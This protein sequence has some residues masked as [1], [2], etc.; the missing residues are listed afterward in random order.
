MDA[1]TLRETF[2]RDGIVF[3]DGVLRGSALASFQDQVSRE[4]SRPAIPPES[5]TP[6][7]V[8][9]SDPSTWP[10]GNAR[11]VIEVVP[12]G[13]GEHW[14]AL[15]TAPE[16]VRALD[17][18][19]GDGA[20]E[21][22][23]NQPHGGPC[24]VRHW[25]CPVVFPEAAA[26]DEPAA[27]DDP[28]RARARASWRRG[29]VGRDQRAW[30]PEEDAL[31]ARLRE[32]GREDEDDPAAAS[33]AALAAASPGEGEA[34]SPVP[35]EDSAAPLSWEA[36]AA[37]I[38]GGRTAK[39]CRE[40]YDPPWTP[41]QDAALLALVDRLGASWNR[42]ADRLQPARKCTK[43]QAR[44]R[45]DVLL[46]ARGGKDTA[47]RR[48]PTTGGEV[49]A[50][51]PDRILPNATVSRADPSSRWEPVNRRRVRG[52][53]WHVDVGPG[54]A[55]DGVRTS[56]GHPCQGAIVLVLLSDCAPGGG[57]T[58]FVRGSHAWVAA[59]IAAAEESSSELAD[60]EASAE[61][62]SEASAEASAAA[63]SPRGAPRPRAGIPH[64]DLNAWVQRAVRD[65]SARG[66]LPKK[67]A[68]PRRPL[69]GGDADPE[70]PSAS[71]D[72]E[73]EKHSAE[74]RSVVG[75]IEQI[76][77]AAG[78]VALLHPWLAHCGT[79]NLRGA[80]RT[81]ANG[82]ARVT[83]EA[84]ARDG[85]VRTLRGI[86]RVP[87]AWLRVPKKTKAK[88]KP[89]TLDFLE[90]AAVAESI[91]RR[92]SHANR[93]KPPDPSL[94]KVSVAIPAHDAAEWLDECF[95]SVL[96][97]TYGGAMEVSVFDDASGDGTDVIA[98]AWANAFETRNVAYVRGGSRWGR[99]GE[100]D[101]EGDD[102]DVAP[103]G[104]GFGKNAAVRASTG[105][106]VVFLDAD[107]VMMPGRVAAQVALSLR[108]P[109]AIV[110][111][112][113]RRHPPGSTE[114]YERWANALRDPEGLWLE[115]FR[116]TTVQMPTWCVPRKLFDAVGGFVE[117]RPEEGEGEDLVFFH[118]HVDAFL[119]AE[120]EAE[121]E[122]EKDAAEKD[123]DAK[124]APREK[125]RAFA[126]AGTPAD[127]VLLY[128]WSPDSGTSRVS[129]K[130]LLEIRVA[131][132]ERRVLRRDDR[133]RRFAVWG[134]GRDGR[135]FVAALSPESRA[136]CVAMLDVDPK[137]CGGTY[138]NH[139]LESPAPIPVVHFSE[140][141]EEEAGGKWAGGEA[142]EARE[143]GGARGRAR[144]PVVVCVAKRRKGG[145]GGG[146]EGDLERNVRT[147]GLE[148]GE[149]LW[150]FM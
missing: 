110:G 100:E 101:E 31:L 82:M 85:G 14:R 56:E 108:H 27:D 42:V 118:A 35:P 55:F 94:P 123:K 149:T 63:S 38:G 120:E 127:P 50:N 132:F 126:R 112:C 114:H 78:G 59:E 86:D 64:R 2:R 47:R 3:L 68:A 26:T 72:D 19:L 29:D 115:Q 54:F 67:R 81:M 71:R 18:L 57:G 111:G 11:R 5:G 73:L 90:R 102:E 22:P 145:A 137:K 92:V 44:A 45:A 52:K 17:A 1:E 28:A 148:E 34:S 7:G 107:D 138:A 104:I 119:K 70:A 32:R 121:A 117:R 141:A 106:H 41:A 20:W 49:R 130:R 76:V 53:G 135:A 98:R 9:L 103:G 122:R 96:A 142:G 36:I 150:Y 12:P 113:W 43:R 16:L 146:E 21:L 143:G 97:Q 48:L 51:S 87:A 136:R 134:A 105:S 99:E 147:L 84:F 116:E 144:T 88:A 23:D 95:G 8:A 24:D 13:V 65:A 33:G 10:K 83:P 37:R 46:S 74:K 139:R 80:P 125:A 6:T 69:G 140:W 109:R 124:K 58:A 62:A 129:R 4:L 66:I 93:A 77:G 91:A 25:Y 75:W 79:T 133:W 30:T 15:A 131:A 60:A 61:A 39:Q 40:R 89:P 128:R